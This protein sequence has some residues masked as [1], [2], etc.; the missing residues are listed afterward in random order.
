M[1][2]LAEA[3]CSYLVPTLEEEASRRMP[4]FPLEVSKHL[5]DWCTWCPLPLEVSKHQGNPFITSRILLVTLG[6]HVR[7]GGVPRGSDHSS[8]KCLNIKATGSFLTEPCCLRLVPTLEEEVPR[9]RLP[10]PLEVSKH[11]SDGVLPCI[12]QK[13]WNT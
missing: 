9:T 6:A 1:T 10:L 2:Y 3:Y 4:S 8:L 11:Q 5:D 12:V 7:G 13:L